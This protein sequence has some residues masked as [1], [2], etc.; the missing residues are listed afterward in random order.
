MLE[1]FDDFRLGDKCLSDFNARIYNE[2]DGWKKSLTP[3]LEHI[4]EKIPN[5][6]GQ[7]FINSTYGSRIIELPIFIESSINMEEFSAWICKNKE[8]KFSFCGDDKEIDVIYNG[9]IDLQ[10]FYDSDYNGLVNLSFVAYSPFWRRKDEFP[11]QF[12]NLRVHDR[13]NFLSNCNVE[14]YPIIKITPK[15][16]QEKIIFSWND[17]NI[18]LQV[19]DKDIYIDSEE[20]EVYEIIS[21]Q[22]KLVMEKFFS[23]EYYEMCKIEPLSQNVIEIKEGEILKLEVQMRSRII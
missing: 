10:N 3:S 8:Q 23:N 4:T 13:V 19:V 17:D 6:D 22:K 14:S 5:V 2:D 18:A 1:Y 20:E 21:G 11:L 12:D 15:G 16:N 9:L 7:I